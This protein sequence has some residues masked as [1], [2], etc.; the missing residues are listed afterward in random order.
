[1]NET[2]GTMQCFCGARAE[3]RKSAKR[4][5][6]WY[7]GNCGL[8]QPSLPGGQDYIL[9]HASIGPAPEVGEGNKP[10]PEK[11][12]EVVPVVNQAKPKSTGNPPPVGITEK[13]AAPKKPSFWEGW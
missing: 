9:N 5:L 4:K 2:I 12:A 1:M 3:V 10:A 13:P 11:P 6:Y 7:C 8:I